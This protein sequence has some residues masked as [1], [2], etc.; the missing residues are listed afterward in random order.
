LPGREIPGEHGGMVTVELNV[1]R[2]RV[3]RRVDVGR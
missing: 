2:R 1:G 3:G